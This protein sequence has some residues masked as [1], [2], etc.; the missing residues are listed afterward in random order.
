[1]KDKLKVLTG[2]ANPEL[3]KEICRYLKIPLG[4]AE[5]SQFSDGETYVKI[6]ENIR[7][8]DVFIIQPTCPPV[9]KNLMEL[10]LMIDAAQRASAERI[11][12]VL[13][14][15]GYARQDRKVEPRVSIAAKLVANLIARSGAHRVLTLDL[16]A[17]QI[18]S[19]FDIP[20]DHL[21]ATPTISR[22]FKKKKG[23]VVVA[24][25]AG[26][27]A[28]ARF[29]A[30]RLRAPLAIIDKRR[31]LTG[32]TTV[33]HVIGEVKGKNLVIVDDIIDTAGT[34]IKAVRALKNKGAREIS[35]ACTHG[36]FSPPAT[37][38]LKEKVIKEVVITNSISLPKEKRLKKIKVLSVA[39]LL[40]EAIKRIYKGESVSSLFD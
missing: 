28:R 9:N 25:D 32:K 33:M 15:Y 6:L 1:M 16:H 17:A 5:V 21:F 11:T 7:G 22:Y 34:L 2:N 13:P 14:Y 31:D 29:Y 26:G 10:L 36:V 12:A 27:V 19:F 8:K 3:A 38:I 20:V 35:A 40:G 4:K 24:P 39:P 30:R 23:F 37:K 18:Q